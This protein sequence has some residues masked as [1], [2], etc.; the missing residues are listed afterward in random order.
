LLAEAPN[1]VVEFVL[2]GSEIQAVDWTSAE[3]LRKVI[4]I[5]QASGARFVIA[6]LPDQARLALDFFGISEMLGPEGYIDTVRHAIRRFR[7]PAAG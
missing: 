3:S 5:T 6:R 7:P 4:E 1:P 2:D